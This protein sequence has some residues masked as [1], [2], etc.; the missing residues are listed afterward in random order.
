MKGLFCTVP[1]ALH[2]PDMAQLSSS[3]FGPPTMRAE[4]DIRPGDNEKQDAFRTPWLPFSEH[5]RAVASRFDQSRRT[6]QVPNGSPE[7]LFA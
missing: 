1:V 7:A 6:T 2:M 5:L 3:L 4:H